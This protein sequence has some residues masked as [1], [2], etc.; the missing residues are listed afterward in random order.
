MHPAQSGCKTITRSVVR[1]CRKGFES[2]DSVPNPCQQKP[3]D[4]GLLIW[5]CLWQH[6][7]FIYANP[8]NE[9]RL[10]L[11][12][13]THTVVLMTLV[14]CSRQESLVFR[15]MAQQTNQSPMLCA[16]GCGFYGNPRTNG[17][18]SVCY[19]EHLTRQNNGGVSP[20]STMGMCFRSS[21]R[22][23]AV[24]VRLIVPH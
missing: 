5:F 24:L 17:M 16:T 19:K 14:F 3:S 1:V 7:A 21:S 23:V 9:A 15:E 22:A 6:Y 2:C 10:W 18:C 4:V 8:L 20:I 12:L 13:H 11:L